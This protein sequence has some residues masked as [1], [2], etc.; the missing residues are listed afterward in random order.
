[1]WVWR[2]FSLM[3]A[4]VCWYQIKNLPVLWIVGYSYVSRVSF[5]TI[6]GLCDALSVSV[7]V[8]GFNGNAS[9]LIL[10]HHGEMERSIFHP[11][12]T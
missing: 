6:A 4:Y 8:E 12:E 3:I 11:H 7:S 1:M 10:F 2:K 9:H 5:P